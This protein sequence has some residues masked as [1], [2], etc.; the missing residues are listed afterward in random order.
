VFRTL[1]PLANASSSTRLARGGVSLKRHIFV[2]WVLLAVAN[3]SERR[4][5]EV[6]R[7]LLTRTPMDNIVASSITP[8]VD[9]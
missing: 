9:S 6:W 2:T 4:E 8:Y 5:S 7:T 1:A 3:F